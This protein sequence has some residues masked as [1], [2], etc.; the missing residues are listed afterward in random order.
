MFSA[1]FGYK[2]KTPKQN[3]NLRGNYSKTKTPILDS[4]FGGNKKTTLKGR[5]VTP[6]RNLDFK[7]ATEGDRYVPQQMDT[8]SKVYFNE[9]E[10][11][12][13]LN[14]STSLPNSPDKY[15]AQ[16]L[17]AGKSA[18][19]ISNNIDDGIDMF[20]FRREGAP[21]VAGSKKQN[22]LYKCMN[23]SSSVRNAKRVYPKAPIQCLDVPDMIADYYYNILDWSSK[24]MLAVAIKDKVYIFNV[25]SSDTSLFKDFDNNALTVTLLKFS[26]DGA[27]LAIGLDNGFIH[28]YRV[29]DQQFTRKFGT[30]NW[31]ICCAAWSGNGLLSFGNRGGLVQTHDT[32]QRLSFLSETEHHVAEVCGINWVCNDQFLVTG[33]ADALVNVYTKDSATSRTPEVLYALDGHTST[34]K[35]ITE[36]PFMYGNIIA[37]SGGLCD[38]TIKF[39]NLDTGELVTNVVTNNQTSAIVFDQYYR[40]MVTTHGGTK[41]SINV[42][43]Y[44]ATTSGFTLA[45]E[46]EL[47]SR[48]LNMVKS[49]CN[50]CITIT[51]D[52]EE[53]S[54]F[55]IFKKDAKYHQNCLQER[56]NMLNLKFSGVRQQIR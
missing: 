35:A 37:T 50:E 31:R 30:G 36:C 46:I 1:M 22:V 28:L 25:V 53:L 12:N 52:N 38:G 33:S 41:S 20:V 13:S 24:Q 32:R 9:E 10:K 8:Y 11:E 23:P 39:W 5:N 55:D 34:V 47:Q 15:R 44:S 51:T 6:S 7:G 26:R 18:N 49:P 29:E 42:W 21:S 48:V 14:T 3:G 17:R 27:Y 2:D 45:H 4:L 40:E 16:L 56:A 43:K 54:F 19:N